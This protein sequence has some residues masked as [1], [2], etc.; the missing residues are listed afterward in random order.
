[1]RE[2]VEWKK[3]SNKRL[4]ANMAWA[5]LD[6]GATGHFVVE[7]APVINKQSASKPITIT[8]PSGSTIRSTHTCNLDIPWLP[9]H[10]T[11]AHIVP[12][13]AH[14]S[15]ISTCKFCA[16]GCRVAFNKEECR[17]YYKG[18]LALFGD[19]CPITDLW[20]LPINP[21]S[22]EE[23]EP[24]QHLNLAIANKQIR[25]TAA[26][27][28]YT[29]PYKQ[30]QMKYMH[31]TFFNLPPATLLKAITNGQ[32][33]DIPLMK[34]EL[35]QRYRAPLPATPKGRMKGPGLESEVRNKKKR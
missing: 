13:L 8:L 19:R 22:P 33:S 5:I 32:M 28:L 3:L 17:V 35:I 27:P 7:V 12:G 14:L 11:K 15:P 26:T 30:Q 23:K 2:D 1:M 31:Q 9:N 34:P 18:K 24:A 20:R 10:V 29:L 16:A 4:V 6:S 21:I 25:H